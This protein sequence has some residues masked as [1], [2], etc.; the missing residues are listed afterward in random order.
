MGNR[1]R[2]RELESDDLDAFTIWNIFYYF[3]ENFLRSV[4]D[5]GAIMINYEGEGRGH[6]AW[7]WPS[8][9]LQITNFRFFSS[10]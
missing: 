4:N 8:L 2:L 7:W 5:E 6:H 10:L 9:K 1:G 3:F